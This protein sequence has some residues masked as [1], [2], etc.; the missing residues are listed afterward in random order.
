MGLHSGGSPFRLGTAVG[1]LRAL[2]EVRKIAI[3]GLTVPFAVAHGTD[4]YCV[5][6]AG[7][8]FLLEHATTPE[9][10]RGVRRV[11]GGYHDLLSEETK[12]ETMMFFMNW[13]NG[14][15]SNKTS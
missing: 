2:E 9:D 3:P 15:I 12:V 13:M 10:D 4:D 5:P 8:D 7:T 6:I 14:R 11:K 1:L